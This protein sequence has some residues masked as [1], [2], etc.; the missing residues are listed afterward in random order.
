MHLAVDEYGIPAS[1]IVT[2]GTVADC[3]QAPLHMEDL[4]AEAFPLRIRRMTRTNCSV[5]LRKLI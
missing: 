1:G 3:S 4:E 5:C 2:S